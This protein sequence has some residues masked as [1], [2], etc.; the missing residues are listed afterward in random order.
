MASHLPTPWTVDDFL[1]WEAQQ[2]ER[3]EFIDGMI[4]GMVGGSV[5]HATIHD[6]V[7]AALRD[8]LRG[9]GCRALSQEVKVVRR[10]ATSTIPTFWWSARRSSRP[11]IRLRSGRHHRGA[12]A[13]DGRSR[14]WR[15]M[16]RIS[17]VGV[18]AALCPGQSDTP[19]RRG[20]QPGWCRLVADSHAPPLSTVPLPAI[21]VE[22][23]LD[24]IYEGSG[25]L[26]PRK[27]RPADKAGAA[28]YAGGRAGAEAEAAWRSS[29]GSA[30]SRT[31]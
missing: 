23:T 21:G 25:G 19:A 26:G 14:S 29:T 13:H 1:E 4:V 31:R 10:T 6:N 12:L 17:R 7:T 16:G 15:Q 20:L 3:Y 27:E 24:E 22:L 2:P 28:A 5:A 30:T 18:A 11:P 9:S 8:R